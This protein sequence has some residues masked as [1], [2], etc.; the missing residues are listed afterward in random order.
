[1]P[2][3]ADRARP[4][5]ASVDAFVDSLRPHLDAVARVARRFAPPSD[6]DDVA[7]EAL[8]AAWRYRGRYRPDRGTFRAWLLA[9]V[10]TES[11][12]AAG[13]RY[14]N[15]QL[16]TDLAHGLVSDARGDGRPPPDHE[17]LER[18]I[19]ALSRRQRE[20]V[21]LYYFV[22]LPLDEV[23]AVLGVSPGTVKSALSEARNRI[24]H[25]LGSVQ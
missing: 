1:M 23:A 4:G 25:L 16:L 17:A 21:G 12:K 8:L 7:Q 18:A 14:R 24:R 13:R 20:V 3:T 9:I 11:R 2:A 22:D 15:E 5:P 19:A 10:F 6:A